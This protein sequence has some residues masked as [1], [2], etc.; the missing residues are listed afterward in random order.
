MN[1]SLA[2]PTYVPAPSIRIER[3]MSTANIDI[4]ACGTYL[5]LI[6]KT[7]ISLV[8]HRIYC[9]F[10]YNVKYARITNN[11]LHAVWWRTVQNIDKKHNK[12]TSFTESTQLTSHYD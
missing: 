6:P 1:L 3:I 7:T 12:E 8:L 2:L 4:D 10:V 5:V 11:L 9:G